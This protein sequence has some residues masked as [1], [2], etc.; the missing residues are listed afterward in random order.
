MGYLKQFPCFSLPL[1]VAHKIG[2]PMRFFLPE[3]RLRGYE[4]LVRCQAHFEI[5]KYALKK[6]T[7]K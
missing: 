3:K 4:N 5:L 7:V 6:G 1:R 2:I